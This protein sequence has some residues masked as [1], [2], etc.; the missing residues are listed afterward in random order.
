[1]SNVFSRFQARNKRN[2]VNN[3][4]VNTSFITSG[5]NSTV[6][7]NKENNSINAAVVNK[8]EQ[9]VAYVYTELKDKLTIGSVWS[10]NKNAVEDK[11]QLGDS[12]NSYSN[13]IHLLITQELTVIKN[14]GWNKYVAFPCNLEINGLWGYFIGPEKKHIAVEL[15]KEVVLQS[16]QY[17]VLIMP[18]GSLKYGD[19]IMIK[20]RAWLIQESD[21]ISSPGIG[22]YSLRPTTM[23]KD[24][25][26]SNEDKEIFIEE[27]TETIVPVVESRT[28]TVKTVNGYFKTDKEVKV[29]KHIDSEVIFELPFGINRVKVTTLSG[30]NQ[31]KIEK[32]YEVE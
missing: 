29:I 4:T 17:P 8:Q 10:T 32:E 23:N 7:V 24:I 27:V 25:I 19:K 15:N 3:R 31:Q 16:K 21:E 18:E 11:L 12:A 13:D 20:N 5:E 22:Y 9:E 1:M 30:N 2:I 6:L 26:K 14:T 28:F